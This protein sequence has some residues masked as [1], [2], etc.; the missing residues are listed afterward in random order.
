MHKV[1]KLI[2]PLPFYLIGIFI[3]AQEKYA[4]LVAVDNYYQAPGVKHHAS[5]SGC[6]ND[7][8]AIKGLLENRFGFNPLQIYTLYD[9]KATKKSVINQLRVVYQKCKPGDAVVFFFSGHGVWMTNDKL[10]GDPVKRG[11]SQAIVLHDLYSPGWDCLMRDETLKDIFNQFVDK[12]IIV[13]SILDCCYSA[14]LMM[15]TGPPKYWEGWFPTRTTD[16]D[17]E[18][19]SIPFIPVTKEPLGCRYDSTGNLLDTLDS[20]GD[21]FPD[22]MDWEIHTPLGSAVD[23]KG[24]IVGEPY[25]DYFVITPDNYYD[26][27]WFA[28]DEVPVDAATATRSFN[29][30]DALKVSNASSI[31]PT[32]RQNSRFLSLAGAADNQK[33]LEISDITGIKHGA[34]TAALLMV[35]KTN[36]ATITVNDLWFKIEALMAKQSY[37]QSPGMHA[38]PSRLNNNLIGIDASGFTNQLRAK[39]I[40]VKNKNIVL[41]KGWTAGL[42]KGNI[43]ANISLRGT[44]KIQII[45]T[46][47]DSSIALDKSNGKIKPG[48]LFEV[49]DPYTISNPYIKIHIPA[50]PISKADYD[51]FFKNKV[52]P[53]TARSNYM[54]Y[55]FEQ[56]DQSKEIIF[57][58]DASR[59]EKFSNEVFD[60]NAKLFS[61]LLPI[62][63]YIRDQVAARIRK[64]QSFQ[65]VNDPRQADLVLYLNYA[66]PRPGVKD[67]FILYWHPPI[68]PPHAGMGEQIFSEDHVLFPT[69]NLTTAQLQSAATSLHAHLKKLLRR[70]T[71]GWLNPYERR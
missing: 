30:K 17:I 36:P 27:S 11:M 62:P 60:S 45:R 56:F 33:G 26:G 24:I 61:V 34:F 66:K 41:D 2:L 53:L 35:Y 12:K 6:V 50:A 47:E 37:T 64:D 31:R 48:H 10:M 71:K 44:E 25:P 19:S 46:Y 23:N 18:I 65:L 32:D 14:N 29:L 4:V 8:K 55:N 38:E 58:R 70:K 49:V 68:N 52:R 15:G 1:L 40:M 57:F 3:N 5:L 28:S 51:L 22:C 54:D 67:G 16:K 39:S 9:L 69:M 43:L 13:T 63:T 59:F 7:A 42:A 20:D 21:S